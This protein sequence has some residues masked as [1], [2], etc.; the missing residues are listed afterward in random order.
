MAKF[1][2]AIFSLSIINYAVSCDDY[3]DSYDSVDQLKV[4]V[5]SLISAHKNG[6]LTDDQKIIFNLTAQH[7]L[8]RNYLAMIEEDIKQVGYMEQY[9]YMPI[10]N[11][12]WAKSVYY[13]Y[14]YVIAR[15]FIRDPDFVSDLKDGRYRA[16]ED[17]ARLT[18]IALNDWTQSYKNAQMKVITEYIKGKDACDA[19]IKNLF[20]LATKNKITEE[21]KKSIEFFVRKYLDYI[22]YIIMTEYIKNS[23]KR[24][25]WPP[26]IVKY[27][28]KEPKEYN[29]ILKKQFNCNID[30]FYVF[31]CVLEDKLDAIK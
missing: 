12:M 1:L 19:K 27:T 14:Q 16:T 9:A 17:E 7:V 6:T 10:F 20:L 11:L 13:S 5:S 31:V 15:K 26:P 23:S 24:F 2:I 29:D 21:E 25:G 22:E 3:I 4:D 18:L 30:L 8:T 28:P